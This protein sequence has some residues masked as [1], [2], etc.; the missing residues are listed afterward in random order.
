MSPISQFPSA[1]SSLLRY[2]KSPK[3][4]LLYNQVYW[5]AAVDVPGAKR[6]S[7]DGRRSGFCECTNALFMSSEFISNKNYDFAQASC[8]WLRFTTT[9]SI[10]PDRLN[11][12]AKLQ[13]YCLHQSSNNWGRIRIVF[14]CQ[15]RIALWGS[16]SERLRGFT[17]SDVDCCCG[18]LLR[19]VSHDSPM[20]GP[21]H[22]RM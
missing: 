14:W 2:H 7:C 17:A 20:G 12:S 6:C 3:W 10:W 8:N 4:L 21:N 11:L 13:M 15:S 1:P 18:S 16:Y 9:I 19:W 5:M 22:F